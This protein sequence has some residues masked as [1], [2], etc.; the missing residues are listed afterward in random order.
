MYPVYVKQLGHK[1]DHKALDPSVKIADISAHDNLF[2]GHIQFF[3]DEVVYSKFD[4]YRAN[5]GH[6]KHHVI[7]KKLALGL[8]LDAQFQFNV[9]PFCIF[10]F[11]VLGEFLH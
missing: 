2:L 4:N 9:F 1:Y 8:S 10:D 7:P 3:L 5:N 6:K 11:I